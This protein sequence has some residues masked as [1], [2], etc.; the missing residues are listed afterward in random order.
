MPT[1][2]KISSLPRSVKVS[3]E[4]V[5]DTLAIL[6]AL[7]FA[8]VLRLENIDF[9]SQYTSVL[10]GAVVTVMTITALYLLGLYQLLVR[11]VTGKVILVITGG[12]LVS[13][14]S[15][16]VAHTI[17][18]E[19][20]PASVSFIHAMLVL[21]LIGSLRFG[22]RQVFRQSIKSTRHPALI[23]GAG[24]AGLN[25]LNSLFHGSDYAPVA[26][27][28]DDESLHGLVISG[29]EVRASAEIRDI[30]RQHDV[31]AVMLASP[32]MSHERRRRLVKDLEGLPVEYKRIP[33]LEK[34]IS[35][36][37]K[38]SE[39]RSV[40][41]E[42][43]LG[44][45]A[46]PPDPSL[47]TANIKNKTVLVTGAG[48]SIGSELCRKIISLEP[49]HLVLLDVSEASTYLIESELLLL[50]AKHNYSA[51]IT[52]IIGS[53][54]D[55]GLLRKL[56]RENSVATIFH[57]AAYKHVP[58]VE[59]NVISGVVN[60]VMGTWFL[61]QA[62]L[63][64]KVEAFT[65]ISTDKAVRPT[66]IMGAT[67]RFAELICQALANEDSSTIFSMV[68]FGN[69]LGSSGS[70]IPKFK[71]QIESG[72]PVTVTHTDITRFFMTIPEAAELVIQAGGMARGGEVFVLDMGEP[73][74]I[75]DLAENMIRL[76]GLAP[77][78]PGIPGDIEIQVTGLRPG[79][80]LFEE[81]LL[82]DEPNDTRHE[83]IKKSREVSMPLSEIETALSEVE[84]LC[85]SGDTSRVID[86]LCK[87]PLAL[88]HEPQ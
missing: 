10:I 80:K 60:N 83:R 76:S 67:K 54:L 48:G 5:A 49:S 85:N 1:L 40:E 14:A 42:D 9:L 19:H 70:V 77:S 15:V 28:D 53:V 64:Y 43:L 61:A 34:I 24:K 63:S 6:A 46:V 81:L 84:R 65:L 39:L 38:I 47:M 58:L 20:I 66:N 29:L 82:A 3:I 44:R 62:A 73:V 71:Q 17:L 87:L 33:S 23:F 11:F 37:A 8:M 13:G 68:R 25:L 52:T 45:S 79:E 57:A 4:I 59:K 50:T 74:K 88:T 75:M 32:K 86:L 18:P 7:T 35:G 55:R 27:I 30:V 26:F 72:G 69:V 36:E 21:I 56:F 2:H 41:P 31:K 22:A 16:L 78:A 51:K 12:A